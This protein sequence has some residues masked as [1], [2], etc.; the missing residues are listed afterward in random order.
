MV[1]KKASPK[2]RVKRKSPVEQVELVN[3][4]HPAD[5]EPDCEG[6]CD[7]GVKKDNTPT[8]IFLIAFICLMSG[9]AVWKFKG[10]EIKEGDCYTRESTGS[11]I[12]VT[13]VP[14]DQ[15]TY[16]KVHHKSYSISYRTK[17]NAPVEDWEYIG[18]MNSAF[19]KLET[20]VEYDIQRLEAEFYKLQYINRVTEHC[21]KLDDPIRC[22]KA[23]G[24][25]HD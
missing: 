1:K 3:H 14:S 19:T 25:T 18:S 6:P 12:K 20:C 24:F 9:L 16:S 5:R 11:I 13:F 21:L 7:C 17:D 10:N 8:A 22:L 2:K 15:S 4:V 23:R